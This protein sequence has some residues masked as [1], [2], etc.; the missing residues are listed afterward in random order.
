M[1]TRLLTVLAVALALAA[2]AAPT[3]LAD[4]DPASDV[5]LLQ[6]AYFPYPPKKPSKA[7]EKALTDLLA[8]SKK[9]GFPLKVAIIAT[10]NDLGSVPQFFGKPQP[11]AAFL[12]REISFNTKKQLLV[13]QPTGYGTDSIEPDTAQ[14]IEDLAPPK[15]D[16][17][18]ALTRAAIDA[19]VRLAKAS[20]HPVAAP[21]L[22]K[23]GGDDGGGTSPVIIFGVPVL[24]LALGGLLAALKR[25]DADP[26]DAAGA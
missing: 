7:F 22:P 19:T 14:A 11:Y 3:A 23:P 24:L 15:D 1:P 13:V 9:A 21:K 4:G 10:E 26:D 18:D 6:D 17:G 8:K 20:G 2:A 25:R 5:V 12:G 16:S